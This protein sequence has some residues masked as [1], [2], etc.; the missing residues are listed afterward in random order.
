M[1]IG[2]RP[3]VFVGHSLGGLLIKQLLREA[4]DKS[5]PGWRKIAAQTRAVVFLAT[6][7]AGADLATWL[8]RLG[9][10]LRASAAI[11]DLRA[12]NA[13]LRNLNEWYRENAARLGIETHCFYESY[14]MK[15]VMVVDQTSAD[16][17]ITGVVPRP[18]D[19]DHASI[20][21]PPTAT[22]RSTTS[23]C[24]GSAAG[25]PGATAGRRR[26][27]APR[28]RPRTDPEPAAGRTDRF[29]GARAAGRGAG[30]GAARGSDGGGGVRDGR[31]RQDRA[32][33]SR[34][35]SPCGRESRRSAVH[36]ARGHL[37]RAPFGGRGDGPRGAELRARG[38]AAGRPRATG[39]PLPQRARRT[40]RADPARRRQQR[41]PSR[42]AAAL[43][44]A[45]H[46][47]PD[48]VARGFGSAWRAASRARRACL[49]EEAR[50]PAARDPGPAR[51][52]RCRARP[53]WPSA[54]GICRSR[55]A[56]PARSSPCIPTGR[57][58][59][60]SRASETS[61]SAWSCCGSR[62]RRR[63]TWPTC[64]RSARATSRA[65]S[66]RWPRA[67]NSSRCS[68]GG[69]TRPR[70]RR[71]GTRRSRRRARR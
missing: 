30:A 56:S 5:V 16:P 60:T 14:P 12:H 4:E 18:L 20:C 48:D 25:R 27:S 49:R 28:A 38:A 19:A 53:G 2:A 7:H 9:S 35:P 33:A 3:I 23:S 15:G 17:G 64:S 54:A 26:R 61:A 37:G 41:G 63:W 44:G 45:D 1:A 11:D 51:D 31:E 8:G 39:A 67:G 10:L 70:P 42:A 68:R 6:P 52:L 59:S 66:R 13:L 69:S 32:R 34:R 29:R 47:R 57:S 21:K 40:A 71:Y 62:A 65:S 36:R 43:A 46:A 22:I 50:R 58:R 55:C 24:S